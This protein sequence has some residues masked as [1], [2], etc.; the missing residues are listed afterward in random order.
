MSDDKVLVDEARRSSEHQQVKSQIQ[1]DVD[2]E[3]TARADRPAPSERKEVNQAAA[4]LRDRAVHE[5]VGT[6]REVQRGR[7]TARIAQFVNYGFG[8]IYGLLGIRLILALIAARP[9]ATFVQW[10][11]SVTDP[12]YAPFR[13]ILPNLTS[14][15]GYTLVLPVLFAIGMYAVLH[16][17]VR[18]LLKLIGERKTEI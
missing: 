5:V 12:L 9:G 16:L 11:Q 7:N 10:I 6:E 3:I 1:R 8:I 14:E 18:G 17:A 15:G 13:G 2:T 4:Q